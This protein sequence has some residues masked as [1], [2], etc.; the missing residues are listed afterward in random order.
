MLRGRL[1]IINLAWILIVSGG[2]LI[3]PLFYLISGHTL[4]WRDSSKCVEPIRPLVV[5]ALRNFQLPLWNPHEALGIP[6][7]AQ[8]MYSVL[9]PVSVI[10]AFLFPHSGMDVFIVIYIVLAAVGNFVL[11][12]ALGASLA[13]ASIAGF[14][15]G[16][17]GYVLGMSNN[18][19]YLCPA[20]TA[21]W[22][23]A[24]IR[25]AGE[26][27]RFGITA[28]AVAGASL[29]F[30]GDPQWTII[31]F[32]IG[33]ALAIETRGLDGLKK[34]TLSLAVATLIATVQLTAMMNFLPETS[35]GLALSIS[36]RMQWSLSP[37]RLVGFMSPGFFGSPKVGLTVWPVFLWLGGQARPNLEMPYLPS[38]YIGACVLVL[39]LAG[40]SHSRTSRLFGI[41]S[42]ILLWLALGVNAGAEQLT[43][44]IPVWGKFRFSE[45][46]VGP[47]TLCLSLLA[48][49]G[50]DRLSNRP[51]K[52]W[53]VF[54]GS[55]G[56]AVI[57]F[58]IFLI[59]WQGF[60]TLF[61]DSTALKAAPLVRH[62]LIRGLI[63]PGLALLALSALLASARRWPRMTTLFPAA[64]AG[65]VFI[66]SLLGAPYALHAGT[67]DVLDRFPLY[68]IK[69]SH[70]QTR[71]L[72]PLEEGYHY[73][74]GL[75]EF[76]AQTG[77][78]SHMGAPSYN[79]P[80]RID[81]IDAYTGLI[82]RRLDSFLKQM[83]WA[84][85]FQSKIAL[86]RYGLT[87]VVMRN[88]Y[89][90]ID[91]EL[92]STATDGGVEV[93]E[94]PEWDFS[95]WKVPHRPWAT[96]A[97]NVI[98]EPGEKEALE[99]LT[100]IIQRGDETV[101]LEGATPPDSLG[102]GHVLNY[103]RRSNTLRIEAVSNGNGILVIND[104]YWP[105]WRATI[106]GKDVPIWRADYLV[107]AVPWPSGRHV[108]NMK[109][110]P[111]EVEIGKIIS[112]A[113]IAALIAIFIMERRKTQA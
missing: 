16:L 103:D 99:T 62:N 100:G 86:R 27:R 34:A 89:S 93:L 1:K 68:Q 111:F 61:T 37:W 9:H 33:F 17:S 59:N 45:K 60:D 108:L 6:L 91:A 107:R 83:S 95:V 101:V 63:H 43:H 12:R 14:G 58:V 73:P 92:A 41:S 79:V 77:A 106:D 24:G 18:I 55:A 69:N 38:V 113:G 88:P 23:I 10:G 112:M 25:M 75:D 15:F 44:F 47:L 28:A 7:F 54:S 5:E 85:G 31:A 110:E 104:S 96:F 29:Y 26:G 82:P 22:C 74:I 21:P 13:A 4:V 48:A 64:M 52:L 94:I 102:T 30:S 39:A 8:M 50:T 56:L 90:D 46:I 51:S 84:F 57:V 70:E 78:H 66:Q 72:T 19:S 109:Y 49:F 97:E 36:D 11:A 81:Q 67:R 76:D 35:R 65:L 80:S 32:V 105:G 42:L 98:V 87:H 53:T 20:A 3:P 40:I 71:I 2:A